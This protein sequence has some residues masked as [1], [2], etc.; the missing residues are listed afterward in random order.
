MYTGLTVIGDIHGKVKEYQKIISNVDS[1]IQLGDF[2]F[3]KEHNWHIANVDSNKHK[4]VF[5][6]HDDTYFLDFPHSLGNTS[7][8]AELSILTI[9]GADSIDRYRRCEGVD[10]FCDEELTYKQLLEAHNLCALYKPRIIITHDC[11]QEI[12]ASLF[13]ITDRS[14][15]RQC[16]QSIFELHQ[17]DLWLFGHHHRSK[18]ISINGTNFICLS[19]LETYTL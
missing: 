5:G 11:P 19:E 18:N 1:S 3:R 16:L 2:G 9:R 7:W 4:I 8:N 12:C 10:W 17:P 6:N 14:R 15:T 13:G